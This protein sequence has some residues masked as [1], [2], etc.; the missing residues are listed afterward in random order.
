MATAGTGDVLTGMTAGLLAQG[1]AV[2]EAAVL[3][4]YLHGAAGQLVGERLG[5]AG[6]LA[7]EIADYV[8]LARRAL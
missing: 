6:L 2:Y 7:H 1:M 4:G 8:P 5:N 3:G